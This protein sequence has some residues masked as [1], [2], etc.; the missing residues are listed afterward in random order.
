MRE[1]LRAGGLS[2]LYAQQP[3]AESLRA[4]TVWAA[5]NTTPIGLFTVQWE[6]AG[7]FHGTGKELTVSQEQIEIFREDY[8]CVSFYSSLISARDQ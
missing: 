6:A 7:V 1:M 4:P 8:S 3:I 2:S 5:I